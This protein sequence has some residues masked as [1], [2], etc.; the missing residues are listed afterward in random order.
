MSSKIFSKPLP[1]I[2]LLI[3]HLI[4]GA[5][6][7]VAKI[8][9]QEFPPMSLALFRFAFASLF[10]APFFLAETKKIKIKKQDLPKLIAIGILIITL[11]ITFFFEGIKRTTV[12][13][14]STLT[15]TIPILSI[16]LGWWFL[17]EKIYLINLLGIA[18]GFLGALLILGLPQI[19][20]GTASA[21]VLLGNVLIILASMC[22][23]LGSVVAKPILSKYPSL[24]VTAIAF[25]L[26]TVTFFIPAA[27]EYIKNP[28]WPI[29]ITV[30]GILGLIY[31]TL[32]SSISAYFLFEWGLSK[33][34]V[35]VANLF[36]YIEPFVAAALAILILGERISQ[37][38]IIGAALIAVGVYLGTLA[39]AKHHHYKAHRI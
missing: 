23:V 5:N 33:T 27:S 28:S 29:Q 35:A 7:V 21:Q 11:N 24:S 3:A 2:A 17:K 6:F 16:I 37:T 8:T 20:I 34:N 13:N 15:L 18:V 32:L 36:Q 10:L 39:K 12:I 25:L 4:W 38:F 22:W 14:A 31:M 19:I 26:G 30:L 1:Y 9:L